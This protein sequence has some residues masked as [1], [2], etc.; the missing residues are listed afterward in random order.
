MILKRERNIHGDQL[1]IDDFDFN[2]REGNITSSKKI[3]KSS[4]KYS[5][6]HLRTKEG[7]SRSFRLKDQ[8]TN[9]FI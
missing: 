4:N 3:F 5:A 2:K 6:I 9:I 7:I 8:Y 1:E